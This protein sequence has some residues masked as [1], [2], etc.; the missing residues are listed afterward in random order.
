M[1][2]NQDTRKKPLDGSTAWT[3]EFRTGQSSA[4]LLS[5]TKSMALQPYTTLWGNSTELYRTWSA[6]CNCPM[7]E[8]KAMVIPL[9]VKKLTVKATVASIYTSLGQR[10]KGLTIYK[11]NHKE[12][13]KKLGSSHPTTRWTKQRLAEVEDYWT[14]VDPS[15]YQARMTASK[16]RAIIVGNL[17]GTPVEIRLYS[18]ERRQYLVRIAGGDGSQSHVKPSDLIFIK[19]TPVCA[20]GL[21]NANQYNGEVGVTKDYSHKNGRYTVELQDAEKLITVKPE[22]L[23]AQYQPDLVFDTTRTLAQMLSHPIL[24]T[25]L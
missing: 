25:A 10:D 15:D 19:G 17:N 12:A 4:P 7:R 8:V 22:N 9:L 24:A 5:P 1:P 3:G 14:R 11:E 23:L 16:G 21:Q 13:R 6:A 18:C 20:H 2:T